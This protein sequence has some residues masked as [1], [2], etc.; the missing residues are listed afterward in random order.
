MAPIEK[1]LHGGDEAR[2]VSQARNGEVAALDALMNAHRGRILNLAWQILRDHEAAEDA[3]QEA[4]VRVFS[5]L[6][7]FRGNSSFGTWL[8]RVALNVCL[9]RKRALKPE[10]IREDE[11]TV[12]P[13]SNSEMKMALEWALDQ[14]PEPHRVALILREWHGL[15]Y[16]EI[17]AICSVPV[18]TVRSRLHEGRAR[19]RQIWRD[20][21]EEHS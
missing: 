8:Y 11:E 6:P 15:N 17:T 4:F 10:N 20:A 1:Q 7:T 12:A 5:K 14:L 18:G 19:F 13:S 21:E 16:E 9:E 2:L 3:A